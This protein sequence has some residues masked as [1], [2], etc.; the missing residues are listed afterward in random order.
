MKDYSKE[1]NINKKYPVVYCLHGGNP[2]NEIQIVWYKSLVKPVIENGNAPPMIYVWNNGGKYYSHYDFPHLNSYGESTFIKEL[3]PHIDSTYRT[4]SNRL[5]RGIVGYSMGGRAAARY[6]FKYPELFSV[7]IA[8][9]G[10]HQFEKQVSKMK[11]DNGEF[12][13]KNNSWDLARDYGSNPNPSIRLYVFVGTDD[14]N[15]EANIEWSSYLRKLGI[16]HSITLIEG[17]D[18]SEAEKLFD[19]LGRET[20][21]YII[22]QN[23]RNAVNNNQN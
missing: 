10:G 4:I 2:G 7:S 17:V 11:N 21:H 22:Y 6:I 19:H 5:A 14:R 16:H 9:A 23:F 20:L 12:Q 18:H 13:P 8:I 15:Y 1:E 3:I